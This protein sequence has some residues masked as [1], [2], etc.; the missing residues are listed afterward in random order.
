[1]YF[2]IMFNRRIFVYYCTL[3][4]L[5]VPFLECFY[6]FSGFFAI[7]FGSIFRLFLSLF[8]PFLLFSC[9]GYLYHFC[10]VPYHLFSLLFFGHFCYYSSVLCQLSNSHILNIFIIFPELFINFSV[11]FLEHQDETHNLSI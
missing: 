7:C 4:F 5:F 3:P 11:S 1:M 8:S 10:C 9:L 2:C 6:H